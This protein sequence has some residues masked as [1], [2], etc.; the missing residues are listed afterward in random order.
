MATLFLA[1][2]SAFSS[3]DHHH[4]HHHHHEH[5][6][7]RTF[8]QD[9][10]IQSSDFPISTFTDQL[11][12]EWEFPPGMNMPLVGEFMETS[13]AAAPISNQPLECE[14][15]K[16]KCS[17]VKRC[18]CQLPS[19]APSLLQTQE[20][21]LSLDD[22]TAF[23]ELQEQ[24]QGINQALDC[25]CDKVKCNCIKHCECS[26]KAS[27]SPGG[28]AALSNLVQLGTGTNTSEISAAVADNTPAKADTAKAN[29]HQDG[30]DDSSDSSASASAD[31]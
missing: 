11:D 22:E 6:E 9:Q 8:Q 26:V 31:N 29:K 2:F 5:T 18:D 15:E 24:L 14:C 20:D 23:L 13:S 4:H 30:S 21:L 7:K 1:C 10:P 28:L 27:G 25:D 12:K 16:V 19:G 17:C 3:A